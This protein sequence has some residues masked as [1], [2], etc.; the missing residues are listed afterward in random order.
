MTNLG[1]INPCRWAET[2]AIP[3]G[4]YEHKYN[5]CVVGCTVDVIGVYKR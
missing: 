1:A 2:D 3:E 5:T 4:V